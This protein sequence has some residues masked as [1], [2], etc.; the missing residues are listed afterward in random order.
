[1]LRG[2]YHYY[3]LSELDMYKTIK[4]I[5]QSYVIWGE[6]NQTTGASITI[7]FSSKAV[8]IEKARGTVLLDKDFGYQNIN[9]FTTTGKIVHD[10]TLEVSRTGNDFKIVHDNAGMGCLFF[11][12]ILTTV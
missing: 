1:M 11:K 10:K 3:Q 2:I 5:V 12:V 9:G 8:T 7:Y 6:Q 4:D